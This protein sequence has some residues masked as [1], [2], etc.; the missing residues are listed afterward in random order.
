MTFIKIKFYVIKI[1]WW[2]LSLYKYL[3]INL[4]LFQLLKYLK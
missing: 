2:D 3:I 4:Y 1:K